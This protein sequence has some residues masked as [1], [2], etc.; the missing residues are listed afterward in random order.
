MSDQR[1]IIADLIWTLSESLERLDE[2]QR[3]VDATRKAIIGNLIDDIDDVE[4]Y[5]LEADET[6]KYRLAVLWPGGHKPLPLCDIRLNG[7][8]IYSTDGS[9][10]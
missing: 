1:T 9:A 3:E 7:E 5:S 6:G 4:G 2:V 8:V 10:A